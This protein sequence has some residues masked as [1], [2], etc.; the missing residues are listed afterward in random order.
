MAAL[1]I[2]KQILELL[3]S[4]PGMSS[5]RIREFFDRPDSVSSAL[6]TMFQKGR[7]TRKPQRTDKGRPGF[8]YW[9]LS[10]SPSDCET[11]QIKQKLDS[12][13]PAGWEARAKLLEQ[14][15]K[16]L[17]NW[18]HVAC[19]RYPGLLVSETVLKA[20]RIA[21]KANPDFAD[22]LMSGQKDNTPIIRAVVAA[23]EE[24]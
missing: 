11:Y 23:L 2:Q 8:R 3:K 16:E 5:T 4:E 18:K 12:P 20:R 10:D 14:T 15:V 1:S 22:A 13:T 17:Q 7:V 24:G 21:A 19:Q 6:I 9:L